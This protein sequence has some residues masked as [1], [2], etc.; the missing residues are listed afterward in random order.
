MFV[1]IVLARV[2]R[3]GLKI[4]FFC[5]FWIS[6]S[7][8]LSV[9]SHNSFPPSVFCILDSWVLQLKFDF[10]KVPFMNNFSSIMIFFIISMKF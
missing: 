8:N 10:L 2:Y 1:L 9:R 6:S 3:V 5:R 7:C 4:L